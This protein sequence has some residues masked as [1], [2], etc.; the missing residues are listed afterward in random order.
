MES[1]AP[2][3]PLIAAALVFGTSAAVLVLEII[4]ARLFA[5]YVGV[6]LE[7]YTT[8]IGVALA[9]IAL[10]ASVGGPLADRVDPRRLLAPLVVAGGL[11]ALAVVPAVRVFGEASTGR[12]DGVV[13][14]L[15]LASLLPPAAILSA[16]AP[17]VV[18]LQLTELG[19]TGAVVGRLS[20]IG[21]AGAL[22]GTFAT[23][24][25][26]VEA[27]SSRAIVLGTGGLLVAVGIALAAHLRAGRRLVV[28]GAALAL[29][30]TGA[31]LA[32]GSPCQVESGYFCARVVAQD[33]GR[34]LVLDTL[35]HAFVDLG[36]PER[37]E[38]DYVRRIGD[39]A[40]ALAPPGAP[41]D[42][43]HLGG[44]GFTLPR[45]LAATRPGSRSL[46]LEL[47]PAVVQINRERLGLRDLP[48]LRIRVGDARVELAALPAG[49]ADL[50]V[51]DAFGGV[52]VPW[53]LTTR[54]FV[55]DVRRVLRPGGVYAANVIDYPPLAFAR[56][57][58]ATLLA[59]FEHVAIVAR[60]ERI[61]GRDG[62]NLVLLASDAPLPLAE[63]D[64]R[65]RAAD[66][67]HA[68]AARAQVQRFAG[69]AGVLTDDR[70]PVDQLLTTRGG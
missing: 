48:G 53:H 23:G 1:R 22:F 41:L 34:L 11:A 16:V 65:A 12:S 52:A 9:G 66:P 31:G 60:P 7:T 68:V 56:A 57:Q 49:A 36:D 8:I 50:V 69:D 20:A 5:P 43:V 51:G 54:E 45:Y 24:F 67:P 19:S 30:G 32:A 59:V 70:A 21:T 33:G 18:K 4:A 13:V 39:V 61:A 35:D 64:D 63:L 62:G 46:V 25:V 6:T 27:L 14:L 2:L 26:L 44:G 40:D 28:M 47:D 38:F 15:A 42:A 55:A 37:L 17:T 29:L 3:H 58:V 10:G